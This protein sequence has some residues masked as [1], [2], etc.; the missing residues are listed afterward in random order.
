MNEHKDWWDLPPTQKQLDFIKSR[1][2]KIDVKTRKEASDIIT[3][4]TTD[5]P[6]W[7]DYYVDHNNL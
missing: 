3:K 2:G 6:A 1:I 5:T 7:I 4:L